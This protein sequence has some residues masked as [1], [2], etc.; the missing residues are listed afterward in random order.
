MT[1]IQVLKEDHDLLIEA[2]DPM[3]EEELARHLAA[4][5]EWHPHDFI[6]WDEGRNFARLGG[7]D[8]HV[9]QSSLSP[10]ARTSLIVNLLSEDNLPSY[11]HEA[12]LRAL[13][14]EVFQ[15]WVHQWTAEEAR[16]SIALRDYLVVTRAVDPVELE[17]ARMSQMTAGWRRPDNEGWIAGLVYG[18]H[19]ELATRI[20]HL[21]TARL[22]ESEPVITDLLKQISR[23]ENLHML[24]YRNAVRR[25]FEVAPDRTMKAVHDCMT[26]FIMP[27]VAMPGFRR[28][29]VEM[30]KA[31]VYDVRQHLGNVLTPP[32]R[33][34]RVFERGDLSDVGEKYRDQLADFLQELE[35]KAVR[36]E[37][38]RAR[39]L[40]RRDAGV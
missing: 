31:G 11:H 13:G 12:S 10:V 26:E 28:A 33:H 38:Q 1:D 23:D 37:E 9:E 27:G 20:S 3:A 22:C 15:E 17:R 21:N 36:F 8:W 5:T 7:E 24:F 30:A 32:L 4:T 6:P 2:I 14:S 39:T 35:K 19:Q 18:T 34:W 16:H 29:S 40:S 25:V